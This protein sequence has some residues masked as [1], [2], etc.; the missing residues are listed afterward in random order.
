[1]LTKKNILKT[2]KLFYP[3]ARRIKKLNKGFSHN[4]FEIETGDKSKKAIF[5]VCIQ[6]REEWFSLKKE[7]RV[8]E[9]LRSIG[10]PVPEVIETD[11]SKK[12]IPAEFMICSYIE[13]RDLEEIWDKLSEKEKE[14]ISEEMGEILGRIHKIKFNEYGYLKINGIR[15]EYNWVLK[16]KNRG[17]KLNH[18]SLTIM[19]WTLN[20]LG[21]LFVNKSFSRKKINEIFNYLYTN[22]RLAESNEKPSLI[23]GD[24]E[25]R[26]IRVQKID[27]KWKIVCLLDFEFSASLPREY[28]F[29]KL[30]RQGFFDKEN[31]KKSLLKGYS[32]YQKIPRDLEKRVKFMRITR[33]IA[34]AGILFNS[35][36]IKLANKG[37]EA[38]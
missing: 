6:E 24:F 23:H 21:R 26:N 12:I 5:K 8:H 36:S 33:D 37:L 4:I 30:H 9:I 15:E 14:E 19:S 11:D 34:F 25:I 20:A 32:K 2:V 29:I 17:V 16:E 7:A 3:K 10:I 27:G 38:A 1:M 13:G 35:G 28:D 18:S 22:Q 31:L